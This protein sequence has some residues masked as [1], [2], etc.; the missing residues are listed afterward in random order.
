MTA[1]NAKK[2]IEET[3]DR[4]VGVRADIV[5]VD[6]AL[7][8]LVDT[9]R[10]AR[11]LFNPPVG[12]KL[13]R[14]YQ[15][16]GEALPDFEHLTRC[17]DVTVIVEHESS[18]LAES[19]ATALEKMDDPERLVVVDHAWHPED[20][21]AFME[22][23][24]QEIVAL[25]PD[26]WEELAEQL[27]DAKEKWLE[28]FRKWQKKRCEEVQ[29]DLESWQP[30]EPFTP[31]LLFD[32]LTIWAPVLA[33]DTKL[34]NLA[35]EKLN[36]HVSALKKQ[37]GSVLKKTAF[38][39]AVEV[40]TAL[41]TAREKIAGRPERKDAAAEVVLL[42]SYR[43]S[44][45]EHEGGIVGEIALPHYRRA[46]AQGEEARKFEPFELTIGG[47]RLSGHIRQVKRVISITL[48]VDTEHNV[49]AD[50]PTLVVQLLPQDTN[51]PVHEWKLLTTFY[52]ESDKLQGYA[53]SDKLQNA[54]ET[55]HEWKLLTIFYE[56]SDQPQDTDEPV[57][58]WRV[59]PEDFNEEG[60]WSGKVEIAEGV[61]GNLKVSIRPEEG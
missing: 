38:W 52:E 11:R 37:K 27:G 17:L 47:L 26:G 53:G 36:T 33:A 21:E 48:N 55:G 49:P 45:P 6:W 59:R 31:T 58:E 44:R 40:A 24:P 46:A 32:K 57:H 9:M 56:E 22:H 29:Q 1:D 19:A 51:E 35:L 54:D 50:F 43:K 18:P 15:V 10:K 61:D 23:P 8:D 20:A 16:S 25:G 39:D 30:E 41:E 28:S 13:F 34:V 2:Q 12:E 3:S 42:E 60:H 7:K 14:I 4:Q 5:V